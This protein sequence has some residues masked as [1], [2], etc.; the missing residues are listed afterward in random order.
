[1]VAVFKSFKYLSHGNGFG[2]LF[3]SEEFEPVNVCVWGWGGGRVEGRCFFSADEGS[4]DWMISLTG[5]PV[6]VG[7]MMALTR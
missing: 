6:W 4:K 2:L 3:A 5:G 1:M 7:H